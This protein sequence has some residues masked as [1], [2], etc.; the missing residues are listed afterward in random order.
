MAE[1]AAK[2]ERYSDKRLKDSFHADILFSEPLQFRTGEILAAVREDY[3]SLIW[4]DSLNADMA[5]DTQ[6]FGLG[7]FFSGRSD[8]PEPGV[9]RMTTMGGRLNANWEDVL[10]KSRFTNP[11]GKAAV[12]AH[13]NH[14]SIGLESVDSSIAARFD[15]ARRL[16]CL[17]A[18]FAKLPTC[19]GVFFPSADSLVIPQE[20]VKAADTAIKVAFPSL[21]WLTLAVNAFRDGPNTGLVTVNTIGLAAFTGTEIVMPKVRMP[22]ADA[23]KWVHAAAVMLAEHGHKFTDGDTLGPETLGPEGQPDRVRLRFAVEGQHGCQTDMWFLFHPKSELDE[24]SLFGARSRPPAPAGVKNEV[25]GESGWLGKKLY[26]FV[27]GAR[28]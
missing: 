2:P 5:I 1:P 15:A 11:Q 26:A 19:T 16:T 13:V 23:A 27:A 8:V 28:G 20:W 22:P 12:D 4:T 18:V 10:W 21:Q 9:T 6:R 7:V 3:P 24:M 17:A 14:L 25:R